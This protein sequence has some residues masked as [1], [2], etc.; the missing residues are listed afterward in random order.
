MPGNASLLWFWAT[1]EAA[2]FCTLAKLRTPL[3]K[4]QDT[5]MSIEAALKTYVAQVKQKKPTAPTDDVS[6]SDGKENEKE[7]G[8]AGEDHENNYF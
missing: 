2:Q 5:F 1:W 4:P 3:G 7:N 6:Q 8:L